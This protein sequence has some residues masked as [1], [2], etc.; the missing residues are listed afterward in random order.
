[1]LSPP[2]L[3]DLLI[4]A[5]HEDENISRNVE[6]STPLMEA[7]DA[8]KDA[9]AELLAARFPRCVEWKNREGLDAV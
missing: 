9:V 5:G 8:G 7:V 1:M 4:D 6:G 3:L 2:L